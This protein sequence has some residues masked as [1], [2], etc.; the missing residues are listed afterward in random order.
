[1][2]SFVTIVW[3]LIIETFRNIRMGDAIGGESTF[4]AAGQYG[5][6]VRI[7]DQPAQFTVI[8]GLPENL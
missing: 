2:T 5:L 6:T 8:Y 7:V 3:H 1:M 4:F